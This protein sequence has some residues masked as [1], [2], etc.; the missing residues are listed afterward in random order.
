MLAG[1][2]HG[3]NAKGVVDAWRN[4]KMAFYGLQRLF[5]EFEN[6]YGSGPSSNDDRLGRAL[7][8]HRANGVQRNDAGYG[9]PWP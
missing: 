3:W 1:R 4:P 9:Q 5:H 6:K 8:G 7:A 2:L